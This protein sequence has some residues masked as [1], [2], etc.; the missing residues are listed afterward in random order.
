[1]LYLRELHLHVGKYMKKTHYRIPEPAVGQALLVA[2]TRTLEKRQTESNHSSSFHCQN[3]LYNTREKISLA[4]TY[5][6]TNTL[7][8][9]TGIQKESDG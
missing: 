6:I 1:M 3:K 5:L 7:S 4:F 2:S 9:K 8:E